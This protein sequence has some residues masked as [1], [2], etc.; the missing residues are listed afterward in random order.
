[1]RDHPAFTPAFI[2]LCVA[3]NAGLGALVQALRLPVY[4]DLTGT[5]LASVLMGPVVGVATAVV[6]QLILTFL[7]SPNTFAY[8]GTAIAIAL[9]AVGLRRFGY[10]A[11]LLPTV[12]GGVILGLVSAVLSAPVT[13]YL[14]GGVSFVGADA[15]TAFFTVMGRSLSE[16]VLLGGL[17]TDPIDKIALSL[18]CFGAVRALPSRVRARFNYDPLTHHACDDPAAP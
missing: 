14:F 18:L 9:V 8:V 3:L 2:A 12:L 13:T 4:L 6:G 17:A 7:T 11:K 5:V 1:M 15:V 10:L 16:S